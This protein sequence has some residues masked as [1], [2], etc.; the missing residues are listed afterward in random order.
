MINTAHKNGHFCSPVVDPAE[1]IARTDELWPEGMPDCPGLDFND[2]GT[3]TILSDWFPR[4]MPEFDYPE[5]APAGDERQF[6]VQ[7]SQFSCTSKAGTL[8][9]NINLTEMVVWFLMVYLPLQRL[10]W[11]VIPY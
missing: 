11:I 6:F 2:S 10:R 4:Y 9:I 1:L 7:N 8:A 3:E 5:Q